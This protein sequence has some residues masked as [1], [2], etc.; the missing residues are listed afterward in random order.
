MAALCI[1]AALLATMQ[2]WPSRFSPQALGYLVASKDVSPMRDACRDADPARGRP[3]C[4]LGDANHPD[5]VLW[6]DSHGVEYAYAIANLPQRAGRGLVQM[7]HSSCAPV[8]GFSIAQPGCDAQNAASIARIRADRRIHTVYLAAFWLAAAEMQPPAFWRAFDGTVATLVR[9]GK[10]VV[11]I[12]ALPSYRFDVPR[13]LA[14]NRPVPGMTRRELADR[15]Q[16]LTAIARHW[17]G[18]GATLVDPADSLCGPKTCDIVRGGAALYFDQHHPSL[19][20]ARLVAAQIGPA[21]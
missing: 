13:T 1:A 10:R 3:V 12:G 8:L 18:R 21:G 4:I 11:I 5:A 7:T 19:T 17:A 14:H 16:A 15:S 20:A 9:E 6:G 2:G